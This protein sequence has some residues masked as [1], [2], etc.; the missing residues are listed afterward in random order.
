MR[1]L[2]LPEERSILAP[3]VSSIFPGSLS[4]RV[5]E[6]SYYGI[7]GN[8]PCG[9]CKFRTGQKTLNA[10]GLRYVSVSQNYVQRTA[11]S[12]IVHNSPGAS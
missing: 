10:S 7:G 9:D 1:Q 12:I 5:S 8:W 4:R 11:G 6:I 2:D 3:D